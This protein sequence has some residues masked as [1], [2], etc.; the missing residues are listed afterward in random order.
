MT[1]ASASQKRKAGAI[2]GVTPVKPAGGGRRG[3]GAGGGAGVGAG[4]G[5]VTLVST[6]SPD[7]RLHYINACKG[8]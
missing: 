6:V 4:A 1:Q 5:K 7:V 8:D 2:Q 3:P